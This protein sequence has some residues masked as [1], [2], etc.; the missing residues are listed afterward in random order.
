ML[1]DGAVH[2]TPDTGDFDVGL[3][4]ESPVPDTVPAGSGRVDEERR[5]SL[6]PSVD[7]EVV[8]VDAAFCQKLLHVAV[9]QAI[10]SYQRTASE[11][12]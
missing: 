7:G 12:T 4:N 1:I 5:E 11:I 8:D 3:V 10:A 9:G 6:D 2:V